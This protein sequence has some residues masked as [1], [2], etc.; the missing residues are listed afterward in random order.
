M[1]DHSILPAR[2]QGQQDEPLRVKT[3]ATALRVDPSTVY[4]EIRSGRLK[5]YRVGTGR[6]THRVPRAAFRAYLAERGIPAEELAVT[7]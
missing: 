1:Q 6:G 4:S 3:I 5:S 7:L 2:K